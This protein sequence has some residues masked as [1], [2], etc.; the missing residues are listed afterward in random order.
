MIAALT[1]I[2][3]MLS[4]PART[5]GL[6]MMLGSALV[7]MAGAAFPWISVTTGLVPLQPESYSLLQLALTN[8][9]QSSFAIILET[10]T[11][12]LLTGILTYSRRLHAL[13]GFVG[14]LGRAVNLG[15]IASFVRAT[16]TIFAPINFGGALYNL[17][18]GAWTCRN[19]GCDTVIYPIYPSLGFVLVVVG[20]LVATIGSWAFN[21][22]EDDSAGIS[23][24]TSATV[25]TPSAKPQ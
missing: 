9:Y 5:R 20:V 16:L 1:R 4:L 8:G 6:L 17:P 25:T 18:P 19:L 24:A 2:Q 21:R 13:T 12:L 23:A 14:F 11:A 7:L 22:P 15:T 10:A 3:R